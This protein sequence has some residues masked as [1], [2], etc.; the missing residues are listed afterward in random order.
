MRAATA[1][2]LAYLRE[3]TPGAAERGIVVGYDGRRLSRE[4]ARDVVEVA[5]PSGS[6]KARVL[7]IRRA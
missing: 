5:A 2:L 7:A 6:W 4:S 1:G 3:T